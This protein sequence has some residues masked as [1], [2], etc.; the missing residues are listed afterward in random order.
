MGGNGGMSGLERQ[1]WKRDNRQRNVKS[2]TLGEGGIEAME[3]HR[4][5]SVG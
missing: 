5:L 2:R 1:Y 3:T 4:R